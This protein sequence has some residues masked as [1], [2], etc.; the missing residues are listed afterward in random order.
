MLIDIVDIADTDSKTIGRHW[1][2]YWDFKLWYILN[3][4]GSRGGH[5]QSMCS[6]WKFRKPPTVYK[7]FLCTP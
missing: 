1:Y 4:D 2:Q 7:N 5:V 3:Q 6:P